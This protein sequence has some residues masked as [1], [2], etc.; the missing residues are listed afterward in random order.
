MSSRATRGICLSLLGIVASRVNAQTP[1][2]PRVQPDSTALAME[3]TTDERWMHGRQQPRF[4]P[5]ASG[6]A[7]LMIDSIRADGGRRRLFLTLGRTASGPDSAMVL[8]D[9]PRRTVGV[10][11][12]PASSTPSPLSAVDPG[13]ATNFVTRRRRQI[14]VAIGQV[15]DLVPS[16]PPEA[17]RVGLVWRDTIGYASS[18]GPF[19]HSVRG[20]RV[21]RV[22]RDTVIDG[23]RMWVVKDS[24][25]IRYEEAYLV[26]E[27]TLDST[28]LESRTGA[29][30]L[31]GVHVLDTD[32]HL[33]RWR[34][35]TTRLQGEAVLRYLDGRSF[36]T[37]ARYERRRSWKLY[38]ARAYQAELAER[39]AVR[40]RNWGGMVITPSNAVERR[41]AQGD[42]IARDS[43][44]AEWR[45]A[46]DPNVAWETFSTLERWYSR[47]GR[48]DDVLTRVRIAAGDTA[49]LYEHLAKRAYAN[50]G[51]PDS[52]DVRAMLPFMEDPALVWS[53][54]LSRDDL[55]E[56]LVQ[57]LT[58]WPRALSEASRGRIPCTPAACRILADQWRAAREPR[59]RDVGLV[60]LFSLDPRQWA[61]TVLALDATRHPLLRSA[62]LLARGVG[63]TWPAAS[64]APL[65]A[66]GSDAGAWL[67]WMNG[68]DPRYAAAQRNAPSAVPRRAG[69][70]PRFEDSHRTAIRMYAARTG[71][72]VVSDL[73]QSYGAATSDSARLIFG[74]ILEGLGEL[75][76]TE[77]ELAESFT[78]RVPSR[79]QLARGVLARSLGEAATP[80]ADANAATLIDQLISAVVNSTPLWPDLMP[81]PRVPARDALPG[82][83]SVSGRVFFHVDNVPQ[84]VRAKWAGQ[85][86]F[87]SES[88]W[89]QRDARTGATLYRVSP[90]QA[91][92]RFAR[93][94]VETSERVSRA[95]NEAPQAYAAGSGYYLMEVNGEWVI[96][97][98]DSWIT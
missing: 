96:V 82:G 55:Y 91:W 26:H 80:M 32:L 87:I 44:L 39:R 88:E 95:G 45:R 22:V 51:H 68:Q 38:D 6:D 78:S 72:D 83:H 75:Q 76:L 12:G 4:S 77:A 54:N 57:G 29:G 10:R 41:L 19:R 89:R 97:A 35:D 58:T 81:G 3:V 92:G 43:L 27:R 63:A 98:R 16:L 7:S 20:T 42:T 46:S 70:A 30:T 8:L 53:F 13:Y 21:S 11:P 2:A 50:D 66:P 23:R 15:W 64:K 28:V 52:A 90:V 73:R 9:V 56:N 47:R 59:L 61:D 36:R 1:T 49:F 85:V 84:A 74:T 17:P 25:A 79:V 69:I 93:V 24:A 37:P 94:Y 67:E 65:P 5:F 14:G 71:R 33:F 18:D 40:A 86:E 60:A 34:E 62:Q 31:R 48:S